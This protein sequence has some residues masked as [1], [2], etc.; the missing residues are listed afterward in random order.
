M[1]LITC[2]HCGA[3]VGDQ[4]RACPQC[5]SPLSD[6][7][8]PPGEAATGGRAPSL[9]PV[10]FGGF[11]I[12]C[13]VAALWWKHH[14]PS[15]TAANMSASEATRERSAAESRFNESVRRAMLG[16]ITLHEAQLHP[17]S[18]QLE[19]AILSEDGDVCY[20]YHTRNESGGMTVEHAVL[21][22]EGRLAFGDTEAGREVWDKSCAKQTGT[23]VTANIGPH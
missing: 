19:H 9:L 5:G 15:D 4:G 8:A 20:T 2:P 17:D 11:L 10:L 14:H 21:P 13:V 23:D 3:K 18:Y 6:A 16:S 1:A 12:A 22:A 7:A